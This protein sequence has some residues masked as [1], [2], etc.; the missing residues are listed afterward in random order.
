MFDCIDFF[1]SEWW[2]RARRLGTTTNQWSTSTVWECMDMSVLQWVMSFGGYCGRGDCCHN[3]VTSWAH[4]LITCRDD[5]KTRWRLHTSCL[6]Y[7][8]LY[9]GGVNRVMMITH[10]TYLY[11]CR[12]ELE[13]K[14]E[15]T[16]KDDKIQQLEQQVICVTTTTT[17]SFLFSWKEQLRKMS[18]GVEQDHVRIILRRWLSMQ[19][20]G[21]LF[22]T[23]LSYQKQI[24]HSFWF[25]A[26]EL[27]HVRL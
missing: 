23:V 16:A 9:V 11:T 15:L 26:T 12:F 24:F 3:G 19:I 25:K 8:T 13:V 10:I 17:F 6:S 27:L 2:I 4:H 18:G 22:S 21:L 7:L 14:V 1:Y 5:C 20:Y